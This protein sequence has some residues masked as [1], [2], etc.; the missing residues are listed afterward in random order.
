MSDKEVFH[1]D[2]VISFFVFLLID[3]FCSVSCIVGLSHF[4]WSCDEFAR[5]FDLGLLL[6]VCLT[7]ATYACVSFHL[8]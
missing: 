7:L 6:P 8:L 4:V 5:L 1:S 3:A 2:L